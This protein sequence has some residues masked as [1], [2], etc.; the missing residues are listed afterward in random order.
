MESLDISSVKK[1]KSLK[2]K[3]PNAPK[4]PPTA[5]LEYQN[6]GAYAKLKEEEP[7]L[8]RQDRL[9]R[10]AA[11]WADMPEEE[12][13]HWHDIKKEKDAI[14]AKETEAYDQKKKA[15]GHDVASDD[16]D[17]S[18]EN[19]ASSAKP[20]PEKKPDGKGKQREKKEVVPKPKAAAAPT[21]ARKG[22]SSKPPADS[23]PAPAPADVAE[24]V[25]HSDSNDKKE[26]EPST[27]NAEA[28]TS[29][30]KESTPSSGEDVAEGEDELDS[31]E[32]S[33]PGSPS[34]NPLALESDGEQTPKPAA[35]GGRA[36]KPAVE[37]PKPKKKA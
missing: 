3:D 15:A 36:K 13:K 8:S 9:K 17:D 6:G 35:R 33:R 37:K 23:S 19:G 18:V 31:G 29:A 28:S 34:P 27:E 20:S 30:A 11:A 10:I 14:F 12:K 1:T 25:E 5:Y 21:N 2:A 24:P 4:N 22:R 26:D 16:S 7:D 32:A